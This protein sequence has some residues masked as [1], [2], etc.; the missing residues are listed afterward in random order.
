M[1]QI[2]PQKVEEAVN[3]LIFKENPQPQKIKIEPKQEI[4]VEQKIKPEIK[5]IKRANDQDNKEAVFI[6]HPH[7]HNAKTH[8]TASKNSVKR[9]NSTL[10]ASKN[11]SLKE[12]SSTASWDNE[13]EEL[14]SKIENNYKNML[15]KI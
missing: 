3:K 12:S 4:R 5:I 1:L 15:S 14:R 2:R 11:S 9:I 13:I 10:K 6:H 8:V 7:F